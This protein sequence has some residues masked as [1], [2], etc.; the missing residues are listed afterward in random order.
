MNEWQQAEDKEVPESIRADIRAT[1][2]D[3]SETVNAIQDKLNPQRIRDE[4]VSTVREATV[5]RVEDMAEDAKWKVKGAG[6]DVIDT[7]KRNPIPAALAAIGLGW[8]F[9]EGRGRSDERDMRR[10]RGGDRYYYAGERRGRRGFDEYGYTYDEFGRRSDRYDNFDEQRHGL[11]AAGENVREKA[12]EVVGQAASKVQDVAGSAADT[13][14][15]VVDSAK[16]GVQQIAQEAQYRAEHVG[17][18]FSEVMQ[19]NPLLIGAAALA[20]G[21]AVGFAFPSTEQEKQLMGEASEKLMERAGD[22]VSQTAQKVQRVA[23][24]ATSAAKDAV[25]S[26][27]EKQN[28]TGGSSS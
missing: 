25:K 2:A 3:L 21:A 27:A 26:E 1:R 14:S 5:G 19:E 7:I 23:E 15:Q 10:Y 16:Q 6:Y 13:A 17:S 12:G 24:E 9:M 8:L 20:L 22:T 4:A 11:Q 28:L 18:R